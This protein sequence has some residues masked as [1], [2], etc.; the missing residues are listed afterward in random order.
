[1]AVTAWWPP[2]WQDDVVVGLVCKYPMPGITQ[3][4]NPVS[5]IILQESN[6]LLQ[7]HPFIHSLSH[8]LRTACAARQARS[9]TVSQQP[10]GPCGAGRL[11]LL[12]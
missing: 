12:R 11:L 10:P 5:K 6:A 4:K 2:S 3:K 7:H 9:K 8:F 1:M